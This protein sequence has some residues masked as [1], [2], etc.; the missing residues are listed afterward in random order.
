MP[1]LVN[2]LECRSHYAASFFQRT[3]AACVARSIRFPSSLPSRIAGKGPAHGD[4]AN[5]GCRSLREVRQTGTTTNLRAYCGEWQSTG[6]PVLPAGATSDLRGIARPFASRRAL[7]TP[8]VLDLRHD[9][10]VALGDLGEGGVVVHRHVV[11]VR[12]AQRRV[13]GIGEVDTSSELAATG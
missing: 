12:G 11:G 2:R 3:F 4:G 7:V 10:S 5:H 1:R 6:W 9:L 13:R 8:L